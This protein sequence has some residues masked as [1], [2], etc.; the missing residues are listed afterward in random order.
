[1]RSL[2]CCCAVGDGL[3]HL[4]QAFLLLLPECLLLGAP[5]LILLCPLLA[6]LLLGLS[7]SLP[8]L[9]LLLSLLN[10]LLLQLL[11]KAQQTHELLIDTAPGRLACYA[12]GNAL[13]L[14][15]SPCLTLHN[16]L[17]L[18]EQL[19]QQVTAQR[20]NKNKQRPKQFLFNG[21]STLRFCHLLHLQELLKQGWRQLSY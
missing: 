1:M 21:R 3:A 16:P 11:L 19:K 9:V 15:A 2:Q 5:L 18:Q 20:L 8:L 13:P 17:V 6:L 4:A 10:P 7:V 12:Q 14:S